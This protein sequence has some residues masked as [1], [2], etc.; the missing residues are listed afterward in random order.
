[1]DIAAALVKA[2]TPILPRDY[3]GLTAYQRSLASSN[4]ELQQ[5]LCELEV[6]HQIEEADL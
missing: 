6:T 1:M 3:E 2:G 5:Y 4:S